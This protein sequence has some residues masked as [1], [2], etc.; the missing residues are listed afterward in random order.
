[1]LANIPILRGDYS[2][3]C[4]VIVVALLVIALI[5]QQRFALWV[6]LLGVALLIFPFVALWIG[7]QTFAGQFPYDLVWGLSLP[8]IVVGAFGLCFRYW[9]RAA[10]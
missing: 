2:V 7:D 10:E 4:A 9:R 6:L 3:E 5:R 1:V 8:V